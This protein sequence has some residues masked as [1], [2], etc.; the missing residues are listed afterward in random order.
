VR[1]AA[2]VSDLMLFSRID[3][4][5]VAAGGSLVRVD[6]PSALPAAR[7][8]DLVLVDWSAR[9]PGWASSLVAWKGSDAPRL[10]LFGR[11]TDLEAHAAAR[12]AGL[13]PMWAR[14]R[15]VAKLPE[16]VDVAPAGDRRSQA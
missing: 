15:L 12:A 9:R 14:S 10:I 16:L 13:G 1:V 3:A 7:S 8:V 11:H 6:E 4:A 5:V 2:V